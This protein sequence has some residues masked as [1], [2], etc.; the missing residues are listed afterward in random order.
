MSLSF[1]SSLYPLRDTKT[2]LSGDRLSCIV[3][4]KKKNRESDG[5][6]IGDWK[7]KM[8]GTER[9]MRADKQ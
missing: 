3:K 4:K 8:S 6:R 1:Y 7:K 5:T 2:W 9:L